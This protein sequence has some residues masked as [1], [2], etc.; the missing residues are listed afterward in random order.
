[1]AAP[2]VSGTVYPMSANLLVNSSAELI[3]RC[4]LAPSTLF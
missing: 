3:L 2:V 1:M 4:L